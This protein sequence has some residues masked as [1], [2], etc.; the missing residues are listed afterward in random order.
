MKGIL[1]PSQLKYLDSH[2]IKEGKLILEMETFA[3]EKNIPIIH[4]QAAEFIEQIITIFKPRRVLE[5]GTAIGYSAIRIARNLRKKCILHTIEK[6]TDNIKLAEKYINQ[7]G[8]NDKIKIFQG[9]ALTI[10][11]GLKKKYDL[12]FLDAD[13]EDY[14]RLFDYSLILLKSEGII[15]IDNLLWH[16]FVAG[17]KI[18]SDYRTSTNIIRDF[19]KV[20]LA[21]VNLKSSILPIGDGLGFGIKI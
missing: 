17:K 21:Q 9:D 16:G 3:R 8:L 5:I 13:K 19:N 2:R 20:F 10:M 6:S 15:I 18:P 1:Y 14:K 4:W 12:I 7:S 11:P